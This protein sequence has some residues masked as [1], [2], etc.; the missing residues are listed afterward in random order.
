MPQ[1]RDRAGEAA[2][3]TRI[4]LVH[5]TRGHYAAA[6]GS[7]HEALRIATEIADGVGRRAA[8]TRLGNVHL[9]LGEEERALAVHDFLKPHVRKL[10]CSDF[11][12]GQNW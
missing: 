5:E 11:L 3:H 1:L 4:G 6:L 8:L 12:G 9:R 2:T 10:Q 7:H